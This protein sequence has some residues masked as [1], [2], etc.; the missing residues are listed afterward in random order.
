MTDTVELLRERLLRSI[1]FD[2]LIGQ[3]DLFADLAYR[4][5]CD[6]CWG[7]SGHCGH[8]QADAANRMAKERGSQA[9]Y[10]ALI[11]S[12]EMT[13]AGEVMATSFNPKLRN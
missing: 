10:D 11:E 4:Q 9:S 1:R 13:Y 8:P 5:L 7:S 3:G 2:L 6:D 12:G